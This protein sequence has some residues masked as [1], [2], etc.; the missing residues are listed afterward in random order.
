MG[1]F[2][3]K[4]DGSTDVDESLK[5]L[6]PEQIKAA[7]EGKA[8][9]D[10]KIAA[11]EAQQAEFEAT[12]ARLATLESKMAPPPPENTGPVSVLEDENRA[13]NE[14]QAPL[15]AIAF[16][17]GSMAAKTQAMQ[18]LDGR[19]LAIFRKY[20]SEIE[21]AMQT[22]APEKRINPETWVNALTYVKG[23][24][25]NEIVEASSKGSDFFS[26]TAG[27]PPPPPKPAEDKLTP[28]QETIAK[29]MKVDPARYLEQRKN[30]QV[31]NG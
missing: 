3:K 21:A 26:E 1:W 13:F 25:L 4:E 18:G 12:K 17:A 10:A 6:T 20:S 8:A 2:K 27:G 30:I 16:H 14:R 24:H 28:E 11:L 9:A 31:Y 23:R 7:V 22:V 5:D 15:A 29:K 19:D